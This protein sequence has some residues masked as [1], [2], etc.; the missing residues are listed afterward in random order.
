MADWYECLYSSLTLGMLTGR[1]LS[2]QESIVPEEVVLAF[3]LDHREVESPLSLSLRLGGGE[4]LLLLF[5]LLHFNLLHLIRFHHRIIVVIGDFNREDDL[6]GALAGVAFK[7]SFH[8][9]PERRTGF[10]GERAEVQGQLHSHFLF[11]SR[12]CAPSDL[13]HEISPCDFPSG[14][15]DPVGWHV[16]CL[17]VC[18]VGEAHLELHVVSKNIIINKS[19]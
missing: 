7:A 16:D 1:Q 4:R 6:D 13:T 14:G 15:G 18:R 19:F 8:S 10:W 9:L 12:L 3:T 2:L 17:I 11:G 5:N